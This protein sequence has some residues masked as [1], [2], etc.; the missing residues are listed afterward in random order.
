MTDDHEKKTETNDEFNE[1]NNEYNETNDEYKFQGINPLRGVLRNPNENIVDN[2]I[3]KER[4]L[5]SCLVVLSI[6]SIFIV[7]PIIVYFIVL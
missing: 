4:L 2:M 7:T 1:T 6:L 5:I 3:V